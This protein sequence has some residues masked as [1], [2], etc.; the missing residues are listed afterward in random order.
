MKVP[1]S[2]RAQIPAGIVA[3][4]KFLGEEAKPYIN[5][6]DIGKVEVNYWNKKGFEGFVSNKKTTDW[7]NSSCIDWRI[8]KLE[9]EES[10]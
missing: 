3:I 2:H 6:Y 8:S 10:M 5:K 4:D 1:D 7:G 9:L